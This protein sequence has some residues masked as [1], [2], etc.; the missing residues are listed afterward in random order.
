MAAAAPAKLPL[1]KDAEAGSSAFTPKEYTFSWTL[2]GLTLESF[3]GAAVD[4]V[5]RSPSFTACGVLW[6]LVVEPHRMYKDVASMGLFLYILEPNCTVQPAEEW[7]SGT[8]VG[9]RNL[10]ADRSEPFV[11]STKKPA[12]VGTGTSWG[13]T[14]WITHEQLLATPQTCLH[15]GTLT[16]AVK[17]RAQSFSEAPAP[18][19]M[20]PSLASDLSRALQ[21]GKNA[22]VVLRNV[23]VVK[24]CTTR[25]QRAFLDAAAAA[26][27]SSR[28]AVSSTSRVLLLIGTVTY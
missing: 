8:G 12:P 3:T 28:C 7:F 13:Y 19:V 21:D 5:W 11:F 18:S 16:V 26:L 24:A 9:S 27:A 14:Q 10:G 6:R 23:G 22:D 1:T 4:T 25:M 17:M 15:E 2:E 20:P